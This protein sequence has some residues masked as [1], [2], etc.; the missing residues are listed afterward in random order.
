M[1][2]GELNLVLFWHIPS[3]SNRRFRFLAALRGMPQ[4][5][6]AQKWAEA[7]DEDRKEL[8]RTGMNALEN[9]PDRSLT[10]GELTVKECLM[11]AIKDF[12]QSLA[13]TRVIRRFATET[14][15]LFCTAALSILNTPD[16][17]MG[18]KYLSTLL[19]KQTAL[20]HRLSDPAAFEKGEAIRLFKQLLSVDR[21]LD[22]RLAQSLPREDKGQ[23]ASSVSIRR[24]ERV[25]DILDEVSNG[26]RIVT[27]LGHL[28]H[29]PHPRVSAKA[30]LVI[31][32]RLQNVEWTERMLTNTE[33]PRVRA[34]AIETLWGL[35][36]DQAKA[37]FTAYVRDSDN[38]VAGNALFGLHL[39]GEETKSDL[40][41][42]S[43][44]GRANF[45][46]T[47]AW[48]MGKIGDA[49]FVDILKGMIHDDDP[50]VR[51]TALRALVNIRFELHP[52]R[53]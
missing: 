15:E 38:R 49:H 28:V 18:Q 39:I 6:G 24:I 51:G 20:L 21:S 52:P 45:R 35:D 5:G 17:S 1:S 53:K 19:L 13:S 2:H 47:A 46:R 27:V 10:A 42:M 34:N 26:R 16:D 40:L 4:G 3:N 29:H 43:T 33:D 23:Q 9:N 31:G 44:D 41:E 25:L 12:R 14:P 8:S 32:K 50:A 30:N 22:V 11:A 36:T 37:L 48:T 7:A